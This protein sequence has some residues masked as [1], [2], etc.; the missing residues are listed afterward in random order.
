MKVTLLQE[1]LSEGL[2]CAERVCPRS[3]SLPILNN[4]LLKTEDSFLCIEAT[5]LEIGLRWWI[6]SKNERKG[7]IALPA[8]LFSNFIS[9]LP[10]EKL[11]METINSLLKVKYENKEVKI[12]GFPAEEF[13]VIPRV[14]KENY[15]SLPTNILCLGLDQLIGLTSTTTSRPE[16]C[17]V[18]FCLEKNQLVMAATDSFRLGEKKFFLENPKEESFSFILPQKTA[19]EIINIFSKE[20]K[21]VRLYFTPNQIMFEVLMEEVSRPKIQLISKLV[22]GEYP[23]YQEIIPK[24]F[25]TKLIINRE[26]LIDQIKLSSLFAKKTNEIKFKID[27]K[28]QRIDIKCEN[29]DTGEYKSSLLAKIEGNSL[30]IAF[31]YKF[32]LDGLTKTKSEEIVF[33]FQ[34]EESAAM[35]K[36]PEK[37][38][39]L[40]IIM[41]MKAS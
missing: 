17:G 35:I 22:E 40:Y 16:I 6:L 18:Y 12:K 2:K 30:E 24:E 28:K 41:P 9:L 23:N 25:L 31:N 37:D 33:G 39:Y 4:L 38:D 5:D 32:L 10:N 26:E 14:E 27:V 8:Q 13:P 3:S 20:E 34:G 1:K 19:R 7:K 36:S 29:P 21:E 11:E 15:I